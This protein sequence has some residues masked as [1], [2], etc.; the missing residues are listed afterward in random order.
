MTVLAAVLFGAVVVL[1]SLVYFSQRRAPN[2]PAV[3]DLTE[4]HAKERAHDAVEATQS[5]PN[6]Y[7]RTGFERLR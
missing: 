4:Q 5:N 7:L 2:P 1:A 3:P 6:D